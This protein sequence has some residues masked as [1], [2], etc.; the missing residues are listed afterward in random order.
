MVEDLD[1]GLRHFSRVLGNYHFA[2]LPG[3]GAAGGLGAAFMGVLGAESRRGIDLVL[4]AAGFDDL[5][6]ACQAKAISANHPESAACQSRTIV[7]TG[8]G[9]MDSQTLEGKVPIGVLRRVRNHGPEDDRHIPVIAVCGRLD[10]VEAL[11]AAGF[12]RLIEVSDRSLP[13]SEQIDS[14]RT[15]KNLRRVALTLNC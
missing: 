9:H 1:R 4:D 10:D 15:K 6:E 13:L 11:Y 12:D 3:A 7:I 5:L 8:E 2:D 14:E